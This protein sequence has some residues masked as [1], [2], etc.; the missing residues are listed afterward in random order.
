MF[1]GKYFDWNSKR[2]KGIVD[3]YGY[4]FFYG[5]KLADLGCGYGDLS[6]TLY[7]LGSEITAVDVR[8]EHLKVVSKKFPGVKIVRA[9]LEGPWPFHGTKFDMILDLSLICHLAS[10]DEHLKAVCSSTTYLILETAVCDSDDPYKIIQI[11][12]A[13][14]VYDLAFNGTGSRPSPAYVERILTDYGMS[15]KRM[16]KTKFN[17]GDYIYDWVALN[18]G[19]TDIHKRR[20]WFCVKNEAGLMLPY[21][22]S[23]PAVVVQP[24][25]NGPDFTFGSV[26]TPSSFVSTIQSGGIPTILTAAPRPPMHSRIIAEGL[27]H[28]GVSNSYTSSNYVEPKSDT[29]NFQVMRNSK[30]FA[31]LFPESY[32][33]P[34]TYQNS[35]IIF[36]NSP[37]SRLW[38]KKISPLFPNLVVSSKASTM[39]GFNKSSDEPNIVM[40]SLD[41]LTV[42]NRIW[43]EEW[44]NGNL[45]QQHIDK[46]R[47]CGTILTPS[48]INSQ[49]ILS[50]LPEANVMRVEKPWPMLAAE[51]IKFDYFLYFEKDEEVTRILLESWEERFG[52]LI[53]VG[54]RVKLPTFAE[55]VSDTVPYVSIAKLLMGAKA[56]VDISTN[57][58]YMSG[59]LKLANSLSLPIITN[60]QAYLNVNG[61]TIIHQNN[62][63]Y[64]VSADIHKAVAIFMSDVLKTPAKFNDSYNDS[65]M[66][67]VQKLVGV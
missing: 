1:D 62:S 34:N 11:P 55:F 2:I 20:I 40:C 65:L 25:P 7:R 51:A 5:K 27:H 53:V 13:K 61:S 26:Q 8:Q 36:P 28:P 48:L 29:L 12:E 58:Y 57:T 44:F 56:V 22:G 3:H 38:M 9:N 52:K 66:V 4:K 49:E 46:L 14:E 6:G 39:M 35:G 19:S 47:G 59:I 18:N 32:E 60:N 37:S 15:F 43:V 33:P 63:T 67:S 10:I 54:S 42:N 17:S 30:E 23:Q 64:P 50:H 41:S 16:D 45:T 31:L 21:V 24:P